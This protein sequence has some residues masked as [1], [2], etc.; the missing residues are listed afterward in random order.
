[1]QSTGEANTEA[2]R[3]TGGDDMD[4]FISAPKVKWQSVRSLHLQCA[5][6]TCRRMLQALVPQDGPCGMWHLCKRIT[7]FRTPSVRCSRTLCQRWDTMSQDPALQVVLMQF[8]QKHFPEA[9]PGM[10]APERRQLLF[11][12]RLIF[13][14]FYLLSIRSF[15]W[16]A[17]PAGTPS[18]GS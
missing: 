2:M 10:A 16:H 13:V 17:S 9:V 4:D 7:S 11:S 3:A 8:I 1:M 15:L 14:S 6:C 18:R 12:V 5:A